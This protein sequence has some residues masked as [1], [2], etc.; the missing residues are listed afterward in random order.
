MHASVGDFPCRIISIIVCPP[1]ILMFSSPLPVDPAAPTSLSTQQPAPIIGE[2]P[3]RPGIF[4]ANPDVVVVAEMSPFASTAMHGIVPVGGCAILHIAYATFSSSPPKIC[5]T[6]SLY[7]GESIPGR[8]LNELR[9]FQA[10]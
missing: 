10:S 7:S 8:Q 1:E 4:H 5:E 3:T 9:A 2:S 6:C